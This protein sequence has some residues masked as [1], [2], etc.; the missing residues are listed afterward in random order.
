MLEFFAGDRSL[1]VVSNSL[2][3]G[4]IGNTF[5]S[6]E[7]IFRLEWKDVPPGGHE[8]TAKATD[9]RGAS[10][11]SEPVRIR[12]IESHRM[13]VVTIEAV[14]PIASEGDWIWDPIV[15]RDPVVVGGTASVD[16]PVF[17]GPPIIDLPNIAVF[18]VKRDSGTN[19][20][21]T[22]YYSLGGTASNGEDYRKLDGSA[23]TLRAQAL[24]EPVQEDVRDRR[25]AR[26]DWDIGGPT[27]D[28]EDG[29][30]CGGGDLRGI[31]AT[32]ARGTGP[33]RVHG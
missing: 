28:L 9:N 31:G 25:P 10:S 27:S 23:A 1:G 24:T 32:G 26:H 5:P 22:V 21:L 14:D 17:I 20:P 16:T 11:V 4:S 3:A 8:L 33:D 13:P 6:V 18:A 7:Q 2:S 29:P 30:P 19:I 15:I 12:V